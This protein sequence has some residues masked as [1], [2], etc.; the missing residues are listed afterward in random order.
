MKLYYIITTVLLCP[1]PASRE[2]L[3]VRVVTLSGVALWCARGGRGLRVRRLGAPLLHAPA[4]LLL[5]IEHNMDH[6]HNGNALQSTR[7]SNVTF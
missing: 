3:D 5:H 7:V 2:L 1:C 6:T 4:S